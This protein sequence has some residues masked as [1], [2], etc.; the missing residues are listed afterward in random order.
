VAAD[1]WRA[2]LIAS[3]GTFV[4]LALLVAAGGI[5]PLER[6]LW[7]WA[8]ERASPELT[9][10]LVW[11]NYLGDVRFLLPA[12]VPLIL[13]VAGPLRQHWWLW[14]AA[15]AGAPVLEGLAKL[16]VGRGRPEGTGFGF[17]S[18][19]V[20]AATAFALLLVYLAGSRW[21]RSWVRGTLWGIAAAAIVA[22]ALA[23]IVLRAHWPLDALGGIALGATCACAAAW[24][25]ARGLR[26]RLEDDG[27]TRAASGPCWAR[28]PLG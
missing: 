12:A 2:A 5:L 8:T 7:T 14:A 16:L 18:G 24:W 21:P 13:G 17:P 23:R 1:R 20:A 27:Q 11:L 25:H 6:A 19:H 22:V 9:A 26:A 28:R 3:A 10:V 15:I 4:G